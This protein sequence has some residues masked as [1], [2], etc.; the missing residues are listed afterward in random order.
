VR[1][2]AD[3][4]RLR[5]PIA[6]DN[7]YGTWNAWHNQY[8]PAKYLIDRDGRLRYFHFG[9][10][11]YAETEAAIRELLGAS[12]PAA[13]GLADESPHGLVTPETYLGTKRRRAGDDVAFRGRWTAEEER[14]V[15]GRGATLRLEYRARDVHLVLTGR[16]A[17]EVL[18]D[19]KAERTVRV[20]ADRLYTLVERPAIG[21]HVLELRFTPGVAA[22]A[23]TFG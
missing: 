7:D 15:A 11:E 20:E 4:L 2:N 9:E 16:G 19:G 1:E 22:Y 18:V 10:G 17:V 14:V 3:E 23:F 13:S 21:D 5:Y 8:W 12:A 6:L